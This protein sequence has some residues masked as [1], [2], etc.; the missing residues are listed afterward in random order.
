MPIPNLEKYLVQI[1]YPGD[2]PRESN[3]LRAWLYDHGLE[4]DSIEFNVRLGEG[5]N[6]AG[7][8]DPVAVETFRGNTKLRADAI[9]YRDGRA[10]IIEVKTRAL[11]DGMGQLLLYRMA[12]MKTFPGR[13]E[14]QMLM[15]CE[16]G[17]DEN[18]AFIEAH[19]VAVTLVEPLEP[20]L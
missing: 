2:T 1:A 18:I 15:V 14:P 13:P 20:N 5:A 6:Y 11:G 16:T 8:A 19:S 9:V 17:T 7:Q 4:F 3:I 12:Y 10:T